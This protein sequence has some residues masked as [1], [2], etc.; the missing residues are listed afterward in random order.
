MENGVV[1][2]ASRLKSDVDTHVACL[3]SSGGF[4][5][6]LPHPAQVTVLGKGADFSP[7]A[8]A[9]LHRQ[10]R[11]LQPH[12]VHTHNLGPLIYGVLAT[13]GGKVTPILHGEHG[14]IQERERNA[15]RRWQRRILYSFC[16]GLHTVSHSMVG[17]LEAE[18]LPV[19]RMAAIP[20]GVD[21]DRFCPPKSKAD[22]RVALGLPG[23]GLLIGIVGRFVVLKRH[24]LLLEAFALVSPKM[25][26]LHL[27]IL[28]EGGHDHDSV[29]AAIE[30]HPLRSRIHWPG[31][32]ADTVP[33]YQTL[34]LLVAPSVIEGLSNAVLESMACGVP[35][36]A[37]GACGNAEV[38]VHEKN[39]FCDDLQSLQA[40]VTAL[41]QRLSDPA[42]LQQVGAIAR[43]HVV[44]NY[45]LD[46]MAQGYLKIYQQCAAANG[47]G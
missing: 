17:S 7:A 18:G 11:H 12:I 26:N 19:R 9:A 37:H 14:Q 40:L 8:V 34:D 36:L 27:V 38:I 43:K 39:G 32:Q 24:L 29:K 16:L 25:P 31:M 42:A 13:L 41:Q 22:V 45:S 15:R 44:K 23:D 20:N 6:R 33:W 3:Q 35:V 5:A 4:A 46:S 10:L 21:S 28:G 30:S 1:N 47:H 2:V